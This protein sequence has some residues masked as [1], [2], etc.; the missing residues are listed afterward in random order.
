VEDEV[1]LQGQAED[2]AARNANLEPF[3]IAGVDHMAIISAN[4]DK[5]SQIANNLTNA[6]GIIPIAEMPNQ[7]THHNNAIVLNKES[8][9][10][11]AAADQGDDYDDEISTHKDDEISDDDDN[12]LP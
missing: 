7:E 1:V 10:D 9:E 12:S 2:K 8:N 11:D 6:D 4:I 3:D 5:I